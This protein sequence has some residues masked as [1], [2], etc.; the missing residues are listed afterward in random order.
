MAGGRDLQ[1]VTAGPGPDIDQLLRLALSPEERQRQR[2]AARLGLSRDPRAL[3]ALV[4]LLSDAQ[5]AVQEAASQAL[6]R[7]TEPEVAEALGHLLGSHDLSLRNR[8]GTVLAGL[9]ELSMPLLARAA[10]SSEAS[11][12]K[13]S[14]ELLGQ[15][16]SPRAVSTLVRGLADPDPNVA[17]AAAETLGK[18]PGPEVASHLR[19]AF[20]ARPELR[21]AAAEALGSQRDP[22]AVPLLLEALGE[23]DL[24]V[25]FAA[26]NALGQIGAPQT[27]RPLMAA[28]RTSPGPLK[29]AI[30]RAVSRLTEPGHG[31]GPSAAELEAMVPDL[32]EAA[33]SEEPE[34]RLAALQVLALCPAG[35]D[36]A[37]TFAA[38]LDDPAAEVRALARRTLERMDADVVPQLV[39]A[40]RQGS[41]EARCEAIELL[42]ARPDRRGA[43]ALAEL[44]NAPEER[45]RAAAALALGQV[46]EPADGPALLARAHDP[47]APVRACAARALGWMRV[48]EAVDLLRTLLDDDAAEVR[49]SALGALVLIGGHGVVEG[50]TSDLRR[51]RPARQ[52][53]AAAALGF[54][55]DSSV[56]SVLLEALRHSDPVVRE[57]AAESLGRQQSP[58]AVQA[59]LQALEDPEPR[60]R[61]AAMSSLSKSGTAAAFDALG[62]RLHDPD[63]GVRLHLVVT[64]APL[65]HPGV[66]QLLLSTLGD[67]APEVAAAS[68]EALGRLGLQE[69]VEPLTVAAERPEPQVARA[70]IQALARTGGEAVR[71]ALDRLRAQSPAL[72]EVVDQ[73]N[74][75]R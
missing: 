30:I 56:L 20:T 65:P 53:L 51:A 22:H 5:R 54:L 38:S 32:V 6:R 71:V 23:S 50:L 55:G 15:I 26:A 29:H 2:A 12:R 48:A 25:R 21:C 57:S 3:P 37:A 16:R 42:C 61:R 19:A 46:G 73:A 18:F 72:R 39:C 31:E 7:R 44:L 28:Y 58:P 59:L 34:I 13:F 69:A 74:P 35:P 8:A 66:A 47:A 1:G 41:L 75:F 68:A 64:L 27:L 10:G 60:V 24:L 70:A 9:G 62:S 33:T 36:G 63:P 40:A 45:L 14:L 67:P 11:I 49:E 4:A 52:R 43:A 17:F